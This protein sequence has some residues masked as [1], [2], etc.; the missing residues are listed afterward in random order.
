MDAPTHSDG[1]AV[2]HGE[3]TVGF[4]DLGTNS[5]RLLLVR[6]VHEETLEPVAEVVHP[7]GTFRVRRIDREPVRQHALPRRLAR[8]QVGDLAAA[9]HLG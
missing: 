5:V 8:R 3:H 1:K 2:T 6:I 7:V 9:A 4:I